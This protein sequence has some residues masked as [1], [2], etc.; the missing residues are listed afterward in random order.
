M[1]II[2]PF[3]ALPPLS[4][5]LSLSKEKEREKKQRKKDKLN[6]TKAVGTYFR[7]VACICVCVYDCVGMCMLDFN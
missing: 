7:N 5:S 6:Q 1:E 4:F 3:I 2:F